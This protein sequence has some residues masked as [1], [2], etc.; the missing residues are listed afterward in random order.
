MMARWLRGA[1]VN[2]GTWKLSFA[3]EAEKTEKYGKFINNFPLSKF[4]PLVFS[5]M[6]GVGEV[7]EELIEE[8]A[9]DYSVITAC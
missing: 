8:S 1:K 3:K 9:A 5:A 2:E 4:K 7:T 6:G